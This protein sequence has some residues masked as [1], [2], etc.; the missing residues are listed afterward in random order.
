MNQT[1]KNIGK[2]KDW[3]NP[4]EE[5][6]H[7]EDVTLD[8]NCKRLIVRK[9][10]RVVRVTDQG[11]GHNTNPNLVIEIYPKDGTITIREKRRK[12]KYSTT[13][14]DIYSLLVRWAAL[15]EIDKLKKAR[16]ER[17]NARKL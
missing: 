2:V 8:C 9:P 13:A 14:S 5:C 3:H 1:E 4:R 16:I 17:R 15:A 10:Y 6:Q 12:R 11:V 7:N